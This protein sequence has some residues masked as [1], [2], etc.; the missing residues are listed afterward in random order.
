[1]RAFRSVVASIVSAVALSA[2]ASHEPQNHV[3]SA[4]LM[5]QSVLGLIWQQQ[6]GEYQALAYQAFN[7]AKVSFAQSKVA[8]GKKKAVVADVDETLLD[9]SP[10]QAWLVKN[11]LAFQPEHWRRWVEARQAKA[12]PGAVSFVNYVNSH[13]GTLFYVSNRKD[14]A[15][16]L[17]TMDNLKQQGFTGVTD[18]TMLFKKDLSSK[19]ARFAEIEKMG[20]DIVMYV[21]DNLDD[22]GDDSYHQTNAQ[23]RQFVEKNKGLFGTKYIALPNPVYGNWERALETDYSH[24]PAE[25]QLEAR[26]KALN[27]W[28][29][30]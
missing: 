7:A 24:S 29:G 6:A 14:G 4:R 13:G 2:C 23:K 19:G 15:E 28:D 11:K 26:D 3:Q 10:F 20:Y 22:F 25:K 8:K 17:A 27:A 30:E 5:D 1:M 18:K 12:L 21:G 9:N 16:K